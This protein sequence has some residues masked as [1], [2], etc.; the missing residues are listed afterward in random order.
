MIF[1]RKSHGCRKYY[2]TD[3]PTYSTVSTDVPR[4]PTLYKDYAV[5]HLRP[6]VFYGIPQ[7]CHGIPRCIRNLTDFLRHPKVSHRIATVSHGIPSDAHCIPMH[8]TVFHRSPIQRYVAATVPLPWLLFLCR[9]REYTAVVSLP[10]S[11]SFPPVPVTRVKKPLRKAYEAKP[12]LG[13]YNST[14]ISGTTI[15]KEADHK[16]KER[17]W[18]S[19]RE[20]IFI[21]YCALQ[22]VLSSYFG[23]GMG[24]VFLHS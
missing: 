6:L 1:H 20:V 16:G 17:W 18:H 2:P 12:V 4:Y 9:A 24:H 11:I 14:L 7:A 23:Q 21:S 22:Q 5:F 3:F 8:P 13:L 19:Q 15:W 10:L